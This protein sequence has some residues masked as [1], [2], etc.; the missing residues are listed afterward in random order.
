MSRNI[1][2]YVVVIELMLEL[3]YSSIYRVFTRSMVAVIT[4]KLS[5][6]IVVVSKRQPS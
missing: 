6:V 5:L 4:L 3:D 1:V 2:E